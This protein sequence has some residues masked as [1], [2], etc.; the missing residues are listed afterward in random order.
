[1]VYQNSM[2][3]QQSP[4]DQRVFSECIKT[5]DIEPIIRGYRESY[6]IDIQEF[7]DFSPL[8]LY[9]C[10]KTGLKFYRGIAPGDGLFYGKLMHYDWYYDPWKWEHQLIHDKLRSTDRLLEIGCGNGGF[11]EGIKDVG[12]NASG[13]ELNED[14][15]TNCREKGL[16]VHSSDLHEYAL[17]K[18]GEFDYVVTFQ[19]LEHIEDV[20][21][22]L[23]SA[24]K[25][26]KPN[27]KLVISV[28]NNNSFMRHDELNLLNLP[29][30]H[31]NLWDEESLQKIA[32]L[33]SC[34][35]D[36]IIFEPLQ[37]YHTSWYVNNVLKQNETQFKKLPKGPR[38]L[39]FRLVKKILENWVAEE[40]ENIRG[41]SV[42][43][44]YSKIE[45]GK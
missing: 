34:V 3:K 31:M 45:E 39:V 26:L 22:F 32:P 6:E 5:F 33:F 17:R 41:H 44:L 14:A 35:L 13:L 19:V 12:C 29:P 23:N 38:G 21:S 20:G 1:M 25:L 36:N 11:L 15:V 30:H 9:Q 18:G 28:P 42:V 24:V 8:R 16:D 10:Q 43:A 37:S 27:G 2:I 40:R 4:V 7:V